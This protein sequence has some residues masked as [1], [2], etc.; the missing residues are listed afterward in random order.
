[1]AFGHARTHEHVG[2]ACVGECARLLELV[3][4][5]TDDVVGK[6]ADP[7]LARQLAAA[8]LAPRQ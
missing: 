1:L 8:V 3:E 4:H 5:G 7:E 2:E 6:A